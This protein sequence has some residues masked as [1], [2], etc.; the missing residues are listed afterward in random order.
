MDPLLANKWLV[1]LVV[2]QVIGFYLLG[3][4]N[5]TKVPTRDAILRLSQLIG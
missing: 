3:N 4:N 5:Y 1:V 2:P